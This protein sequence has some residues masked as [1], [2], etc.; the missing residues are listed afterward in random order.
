MGKT[1]NL[2]KVF[3]SETK[4]LIYGGHVVSAKIR[5]TPNGRRLAYFKSGN[6]WS[7]YGIRVFRTFK[8]EISAYYDLRDTQERTI[9]DY[10]ERLTKTKAKIKELENGK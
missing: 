8:K 2:S 7:D 9:E 5:M 3:A 10:T 1:M 4:Y 6:S